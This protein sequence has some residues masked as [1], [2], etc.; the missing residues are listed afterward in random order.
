MLASFQRSYC[1]G[2]LPDESLQ[3]WPAGC[4]QNQDRQA[5]AGEILLVSQISIG[6]YQYVKFPF[7]I[8]EQVAVA[9]I[10][11]TCFIRGLD[12]M[13]WKMISKRRRNALVEQDAHAAETARLSCLQAARSVLE[14]RLGLLPSHP[15]KPD[16]ELIEGGAAFEVFEQ[17]ANRHAGAAKYPHAAD[18]RGILLNCIAGGPFKHSRIL[19]LRATV[20]RPCL[21]T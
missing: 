6:R 1:F 5:V 18:F 3:L 4:W 17:G 21:L 13:S 8:C 14:N 7:G 20:V 9:Q 10:R 19:L 2:Y 11:P 16:Q 12:G 15:R